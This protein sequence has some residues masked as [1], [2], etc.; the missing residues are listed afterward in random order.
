M[1]DL[2][3]QQQRG[4]GQ[5]AGVSSNSTTSGGGGSSTTGERLR[6][7]YR[8]HV[9]TQLSHDLVDAIGSLQQHQHHLQ[10]LSQ[11]LEQATTQV[12]PG[13]GE[14]SCREVEKWYTGRGS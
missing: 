14:L 3:Q 8:R 2:E 11:Q 12:C 7:E 6:E 5:E 9:Q 10:Q 4:Q 1:S 13:K